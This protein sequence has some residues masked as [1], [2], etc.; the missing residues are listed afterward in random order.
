M[1]NLHLRVNGQAYPI[2]NLVEGDTP[3]SGGMDQA[4]QITLPIRDPS[5]SLTDVLKDEAN[6]QQDG[7]LVVID[8]VDYMVVGYDHDG[9]GLH[10]LTVEDEVAW[11]LKQFAKFKAASR[12]RT[13]RFGF[14]QSL[15]DEA[16]R[17][18]YTKMRSFIPEINDKLKV[19]K[20]TQDS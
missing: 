7:V 19:R 3:Y 5:S 9:A 17:H 2:G 11:R 18:P 15:V 6:L 10:T 13:T 20:Q 12:A 1:H 16:S 14:I 4:T 8:G